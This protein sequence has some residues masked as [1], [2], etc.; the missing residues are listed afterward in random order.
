MGCWHVLHVDTVVDGVAA[1]AR[2]NLKSK[3]DLDVDLSSCGRVVLIF[4]AVGNKTFN[5]WVFLSLSL[6][7]SIACLS[8]SSHNCAVLD[9]V[10]GGG[11]GSWKADGV[12]VNGIGWF[13]DTRVIVEVVM[14]LMYRTKIPLDNR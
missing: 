8:Y 4:G 9:G 6:A 1:C 7:F 14:S 10:V 3:L 12:L 5:V 11:R 13:G 2:R